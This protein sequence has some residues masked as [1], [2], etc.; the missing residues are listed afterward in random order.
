MRLGGRKRRGHREGTYQ[1][2]HGRELGG[3]QARDVILS[4]ASAFP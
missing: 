4:L 3:G 2:R 1:D